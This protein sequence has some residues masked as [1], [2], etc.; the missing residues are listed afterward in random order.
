M[1]RTVSRWSLGIRPY[2]DVV[3]A[4]TAA[5]RWDVAEALAQDVS[6]DECRVGMAVA[7]MS[8]HAGAG[9]V[10]EAEAM[11]RSAERAT[12]SAGLIGI[13][14][15]LRKAGSN[16]RADD[17]CAE[18]EAVAA[19][20]GVP[21]KKLVDIL[22][23]AGEFDRAEAV[24][25]DLPAG[26]DR[27]WVVAELVQAL[28]R[29]GEL[30]RAEALLGNLHPRA[31][32]HAVRDVS[33]ARARA[34]RHT[35]AE[36]LARE[37]PE[38]DAAAALCSIVGVLAEAGEYGRAET[39]ARTLD[40]G[41]A[42]TS[43][44]LAI[45]DALARAGEVDRVGALGETLADPAER[46]RAQVAVAMALA[47]H[48]RQAEAV[49]ALL[50]AEARTRVLHPPTVARKLGR[51]AKALA[52]DGHRPAALKLL[53][54]TEALIAGHAAEPGTRAHAEFGMATH[55]LGS[56]YVS[57]GQM[58]RAEALARSVSDDFDRR[59]LLVLVVQGL[60]RSGEV[61]RAEA[62]MRTEAEVETGLEGL[63]LSLDCAFARGLVEAGDFA[64]AEAHIRGIQ[65]L[66][67]ASELAGLALALAGAGQHEWARLLVDEV[68]AIEGPSI[69][70]TMEDMS[71]LVKTLAA[72]G[73][74]VAAEALFDEM[75]LSDGY[76]DRQKTIPVA[77]AL[78]VLGR[79]DEAVE[80]LNSLEDRYERAEGLS[81]LVQVL[82]QAQE[83]A[84]AEE[85]AR[86]ISAPGPATQAFVSVA[87]ATADIEQA[88]RLTALALQ[89]GGWVPALPA[90]LK[91]TPEAVPLVVE[92]AGA[93]KAACGHPH[94]PPTAA[95]TSAPSSN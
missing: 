92:A 37:I 23:E 38:P 72:V 94:D 90:L 69:G 81:A 87:I 54:G 66:L 34:G 35:Q 89:S 9:R 80:E 22:A 33:L 48:G 77:K 24:V 84:R 27:A 93:M 47:G 29:A 18:A 17:L 10:A 95:R 25:G 57:T 40:Q 91:H 20:G 44:F 49:E 76:V 67:Q 4:C 85:M 2:V 15:V 62:V 31:H 42:R 58:E 36:A 60:A 59:D 46:A 61:P 11:A 73:D 43:A 79:L 3:E 65:P 32:H 1:V 68:A 12:S 28:A 19:E 53:D 26:D 14:S 6:D 74:R 56:A 71:V 63:I 82:V 51:V 16:E 7:L 13:A 86:T 70:P 83:F 30:D 8:A 5:S 64:G 41:T 50:E 55:A 78:C 88:R 21:R 52:D 75:R 39:L 45:V